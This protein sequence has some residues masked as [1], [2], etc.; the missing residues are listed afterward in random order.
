MAALARVPEPRLA[1]VAADLGVTERTLHRRVTAAVGYG[2][3]VLQ[4]VARFRRF[5]GR[6]E[7]EPS[8]TLAHLAVV[9]GYADQS[10]LARDCRTLA[11]LTPAELVGQRGVRSV[12]DGLL[13]PR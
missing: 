1:A 9:A 8:L 5:L 3:K 6:A 13:P 10:H 2:P 12:Q 4:R 7:S 11:D